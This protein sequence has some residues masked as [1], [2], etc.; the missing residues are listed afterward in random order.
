MKADVCNLLG[1]FYRSHAEKRLNVHAAARIDEAEK[2]GAA[3]PGIDL[4][5]H[6]ET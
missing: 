5:G 1:T 6:N 4:D 3:P 2:V